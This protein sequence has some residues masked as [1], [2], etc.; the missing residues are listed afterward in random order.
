MTHSALQRPDWQGNPLKQ[1]ELF[2][3][4][5]DRGERR[6]EAVA[7]LWTH[8]LGWELRLMIAGDLHRSEVCRSQDDVLTTG[9]QWKAALVEKE[10][11]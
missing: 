4:H 7:E 10:W 11:E 3:V 2:R 6:I 1:G 9:E 8:Q 5:K